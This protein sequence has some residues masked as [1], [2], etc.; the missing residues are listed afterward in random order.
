RAA[1]REK[2]MVV[3]VALGASRGRLAQQLLVESLLLAGLGGAAGLV[4]ALVG[5]PAVGRDLSAGLFRAAAAT[6]ALRVLAFSAGSALTTGVAF[7]IAPLFGTRHVSLDH[8]LRQNSR[9]IGGA[10]ARMRNTLAA[11]QVAIAIVLLIGAG[12]MAK[13]FWALMH[14]PK[15]FRS[16]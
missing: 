7:G 3:R 8:S 12:L 13:S 1:A 16:E 14:V 2:E 6:L 4:L 10:R 15:G 5:W 9:A 11:A